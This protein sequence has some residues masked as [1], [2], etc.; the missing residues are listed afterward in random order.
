VIGNQ[1]L[2][3]SSA[4][5][6]PNAQAGLGDVEGQL[7]WRWAAESRSRPEIFSYF[8]TVFPL[9]KD[10]KLIGTPAWEFKLGTGVV[11]GLSW[12]TLTLRLAAEYDGTEGTIEAGEFAI[13]Y[14]KRVSRS[15]RVYLGVE[16][17]QDEIEAIP[18]VQWS[19]RPNVTLKLNSAFGVT[20]KATDWAPEIG[21]L[22]SLR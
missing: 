19:V 6:W 18:E 8:E 10:R 4:K 2:L 13:E 14:L 22:V 1:S 3:D 9:Q 20:S 5:A 15:A 7:R 17:S 11:R 16:G 12:G 21:A